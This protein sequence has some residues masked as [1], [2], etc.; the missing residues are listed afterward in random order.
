M[1]KTFTLLIASLFAIMLITQPVKVMGQTRT[2][3]YEQLTSIANIDESAQYV[4]GISGTG[5]HYQGTSSWGE[6]S[7]SSTPLYYT[8]KK[9]TDGKSFTAKTTISNTVYYLQIPTSNTFSMATTT[10]TNTDII[11]GTTQVSGTNYAVAN[12]STTTRHLRVNTGNPGGLRS[13]A[14]TSGNMAYF[15][16]VKY[17]VKYDCN[18]GDSG[19]PT[20]TINNVPSG[21]YTLAAAPTRENYTFDGWS[22]GTNTYD[23]G[24]TYPLYS[25]NVTFTAQWTSSLTPCNLAITG[26]P[27]TLNFDLYNNYSPQ[28]VYYTTSGTGDVTVD[29]SDYVNTTVTF[30]SDTKTISVSPKS[31]VTPSAQTI[32]VRQAADAS[33]AAGTATF[34]VNITNSAPSITISGSG[35]TNNAVNLDYDDDNVHTASVAY[36]NLN[37][38]EPTL[39]IYSDFDCTEPYEGQDFTANFATNDIETIEYV[40]VEENTDPDNA[41]TVYIRVAVSTVYSNVITITQG[42]FI[43]SYDVIFNTDGGTFVGNEDFPNDAEPKEEGTYT[44]PSATKTNYTFAGW[45]DG[46]LVYAAGASYTISANVEFTAQWVQGGTIN[47]GNGSGDLTINGTSVN[48]NDSFGKSWSVS[49]VFPTATTSF[50]QNA[51]YSQVGSTNTPATSITFTSTIAA[52][53]VTILSFSANFSGGA[54]S[55]IG[56]VTLKVGDTPVGTGTI[57][58]TGSVTVTN[59]KQI[60]GTALTVTVTGITASIKCYSISYTFTTSDAPIIG[61]PSSI[62]IYSDITNN[63]FDYGILHPVGGKSLTATSTTGWISNIEVTGSKVTFDADENNSTEDNRNGTIKLSYDGAVSKIVTITQSKIDY[64]TLSPDPFAYDEAGTSNLP[65]GLTSNLSGS[66]A[67]SPKMKFDATGKYLVLHLHTVPSSLSYD[68]KGNSFNS[69]TFKV[70]TSSNGIDYVD[71]ATYTSLDGSVQTVTHIVPDGTRFIKW[72]YNKNGSNGGNVALGNIKA[73]NQYDIY[74]TVSV[75]SLSPTSSKKCTIYNGGILTVTGT[76]ENETAANLIINDGGQLYTTSSDVQATFKKT[77]ATSTNNDAHWY[78]ISS[79]VTN[80][81][82][83]ATPGVTIT[84]VSNLVNNEVTYNLYR[85]VENAATYQWEAYNPSEGHHTDFTALLNGHGYLYRNNGQL[86][87]FTGKVNVGDVGDVEV[88]VTAASSNNDIKGFNLLGNPYSHDI[89]LKHVKTDKDECFYNCYILSGEGSWEAGTLYDDENSIHPCQGFFVQADEPATAT[90]S[91]NTQRGINANGDFIKFTVANN[92]YKDVAYAIFDKGQDL[93][94]INHRNA[95]IQQIYI[96]KDDENFAVAIMADNTQSFNLNF[97]AMTMGQYT[98]SF[99]AKGEFNYLHVIDRMTGND[100]D[101]LLEGEY[102]FI[103]SPQ[104]NEARFIV[105]LGYLPNYDNNGADIFAYQNGSDVIVSGEGE[106]Q[107][108]DVMGRMVSTQNVNGT[109]TISVN[110]QGVYIFRLVGTEIKTQKIVVR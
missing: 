45:Y 77:I 37:N 7:S 108:F 27:V 90:I 94:K 88:P 23:A 91:K 86:L 19:C 74:G 52:S 35:I 46:D 9:A 6:I 62:D 10:G 50:T 5:F 80:T 20:T 54:N 13:Y 64:A 1:K 61:A 4:L 26:S 71:L 66:Y 75:A 102:N 3:T 100:I 12:K 89:T 38:P 14:S 39:E 99:K 56:T 31:I 96:P 33:H 110:A 82:A 93:T 98:L 18:G 57:S 104:D 43:Q 63:E 81:E 11:I 25:D 2:T 58:G 101:M 36:N 65:T 17:T 21:N 49:S 40:F 48:G 72:S 69:S 59:T 79:P 24:A 107:I 47:F 85:Y 60:D 41:R 15:Y 67:N 32:T 42:A 105:R 106:L 73:S 51:N 22:D 29:A 76:L 92:E 95:K 68:I 78:T 55:S 28:T 103:G 83:P 8:L 87:T 44:L 30:T 84:S 53:S 34:S 109:E 16:K 97:K 70:Q